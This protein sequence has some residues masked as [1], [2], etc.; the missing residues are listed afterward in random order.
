MFGI[1][2]ESEIQDA[3]HEGVKQ[4]HP[5]LYENYASLRADAEEHF[6]QIQVAYRELKEHNATPDELP[7]EFS[8]EKAAVKP[9]ETPSISFG[10]APGCLTAQQ[11]TPEVEE[12]IAGCLG[13]LGTALAIVDL[14]G[15]RSHA[16]INSQFLLLATRGIMVRDSR[17]MTSLLWYADLG[18]ITLID[19]RRN[20]K[21]S[22]WHKLVGN[23]SG[24]QPD[25]ELQIY[26]SN[27]TQFCSISSRADDSV[28]TAIYDFLMLQKSQT[29]S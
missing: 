13:K 26:R 25:Y 14:S 8:V 12:F 4:W 7:E 16:G 27:G 19:R 28:K 10:D 22:S 24:N 1:P 20:S 5:D 3:Y 9:E 29:H 2:S 6:K 21:L 11:F 18:E 15:A 23:I 17:N